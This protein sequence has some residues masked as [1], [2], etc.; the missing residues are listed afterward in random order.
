VKL[1]KKAVADLLDTVPAELTVRIAKLAMVEGVREAKQVRVRRSGPELFVDLCLVVDGS[2]SLDRGHE[3]AC[4]AEGAIKR[5]LPGADIVVHVEP[6]ER[7][8]ED[9]L[10]SARM[11]AAAH[12]ASAHNL[13]AFEEAGRLVLELHL[14]MDANL[15]LSQAHARSNDIEQELCRVHP[16]LARVI[17]HVEPAGARRTTTSASPEDAAQV[18]EALQQLTALG[19]RRLVPQ[20]VEIRGYG[21]ELSLSF[22]CALPGETSIKDAHELTD[23]IERALRARLPNLGRVTIHTE[24]AE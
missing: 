10:D 17:T 8:G 11:T 3:I 20:D 6:A 4:A 2:E 18:R 16:R 9:L 23:T 24:P 15:P 21:A 5:E 19:E 22:R 1:G 12:G 7:S 14:E 13:L